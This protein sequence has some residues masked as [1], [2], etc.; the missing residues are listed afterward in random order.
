ME[1]LAMIESFLEK[2]IG[3][4]TEAIGSEVISK[5]VRVRMADLGLPDAVAYHD[6]LKASEKEQAA[7]I[8]AVVVPETWFFRNKK[9]FRFLVDYVTG[10]WFRENPG[11]RL[12][13]LS[14]PCSTGEEAYSIAMSLMDAGIQSDRFHIDG[15]DISERALTRARTAVYEQGSFRGEDLWFR[16]RYFDPEGDAFRLHDDVRKTVR[17]LKENVLNDRLLKD[18]EPYDIIFY[19]NLLIYLSPRAKQR[20]LE[21]VGRLLAD[22]GILFL[23]HAERETAVLCGL[24]GIPEFG[25]FACRKDRRCKKRMVKPAAPPDP[26]RRRFEKVGKS[27]Q[28]PRP[29]VPAH[30]AVKIPEDAVLDRVPNRSEQDAVQGDLFDEAQRLADRGSLGSALELCRSCL[31]DHPMNAGVHFLM[32]LIYEALDSPEKAEESFNKAI[33]LEPNH[34]EALNHLSFIVENRGDISRAAHLRERAQRV[35]RQKTGT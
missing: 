15:V 20:T 25:V 10:T 17:F 2:K 16:K 9:A 1:S 8:E 22:S 32:G 24:A 34:S 12:R 27:L 29:P 23:G 6:S 14:I 26:C 33:Y 11:R 7:L 4:S 30:S 13:V 3:L 5:A 35:S 19:R 18:Q 28:P 31:N 21:I